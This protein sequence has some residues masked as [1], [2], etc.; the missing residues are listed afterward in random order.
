MRLAQFRGGSVHAI[1]AMGLFIPGRVEDADPEP[2]D[3]GHDASHRPG[4]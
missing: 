2:R 1:G 3:S 4:L